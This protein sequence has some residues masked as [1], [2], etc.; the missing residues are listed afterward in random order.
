MVEKPILPKKHP[1]TKYH[2]TVTLNKEDG[3]LVQSGD[4]IMEYN[5]RTLS[6]ASKD[7]N[8]TALTDKEDTVTI[9]KAITDQQPERPTTTEDKMSLKDISLL[10]E[11][12]QII[13]SIIKDLPINDEQRKLFTNFYTADKAPER[14]LFR[15]AFQQA[16]GDIILL[17]KIIKQIDDLSTP[18][19]HQY[20]DSLVSESHN[21]SDS[22]TMPPPLHTKILYVFFPNTPEQSNTYWTSHC[23][24][25]P[26]PS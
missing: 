23:I 22:P 8:L 13:S 26:Q 9:Q 5:Q 25:P 7:L 16:K 20:Y 4:V 10:I 15:K 14:E 18:E 12:A 21:P 19:R 1:N 2:T 3:T 17:D 24:T 6:L 11:Y